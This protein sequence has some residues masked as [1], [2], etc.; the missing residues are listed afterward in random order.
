MQVALLQYQITALTPPTNIAMPPLK[1]DV[2]FVD[3][4]LDFNVEQASEILDF[5][6]IFDES[7]VEEEDGRKNI[8]PLF[9]PIYDKS[10]N[11][12]EDQSFNFVQIFKEDD[13]K[14]KVSV[15]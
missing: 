7:E 12:E 8:D 5:N 1:D 6:P 13:E 10:D 2:D 4:E 14:N 9:D 11:E 15:S 3:D